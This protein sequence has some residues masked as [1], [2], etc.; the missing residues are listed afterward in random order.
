M[1]I[2]RRLLLTSLGALVSGPFR[3]GTAAEDISEGAAGTMLTDDPSRAFLFR[4]F[5]EIPAENTP[6]TPQ[7]FVLPRSFLFPK[8]TQID[9]KGVERKDQRFGIDISHHNGS[10][11]DFSTLRAQNVFF[12]YV[13]AGQARKQDPLFVHNWSSLGA[14][15]GAKSVYR[16]AYFFLSSQSSGEEQGRYFANLLGTLR[17]SDLPPVVDLE[18]DISRTNRDQW[19]KYKG[20]QIINEVLA[21]LKPITDGRRQPIIYTAGSWLHERIGSSAEMARLSQF[22]IWLADYSQSAL[23]IESPAVPAGLTQKLWQFTDRSE[24]IEGYDRALD[25]SIYRGTDDQFRADFGV[26]AL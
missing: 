8:Y 24:L 4:R 22:K 21:F 7:A 12:C 1:V 14:L 26:I 6:G 2:S 10:D 3:G 9:D 5:I 16:G 23:G 25:A 15:T 13:K 18:W 20:H 19:A 17:T 11:I